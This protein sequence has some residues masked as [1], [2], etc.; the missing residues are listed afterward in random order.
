MAVRTPT[1]RASPQAEH[2]R[3]RTLP[4]LT[5]L[6]HQRTGRQAAGYA[7]ATLGTV[8][9]TLGLLG[10]RDH[11][12]LLSKGL[13]FLVVVVVAAAVGGL[14]PGLLASLLGFLSFNLFFVPPYG[15]VV[16][17]RVEHDVVLVVFLGLSILISALLARANE[18]AAAAEA[19][20]D[21]RGSPTTTRRCGCRSWSVGRPWACWSSTASARRLLQQRAGCCGRS[22]TSSPWCWSGTGCWM[23]PPRPRPSGGPISCAG[24]CWRRS[25]TICAARWPPSKH[26]P[27]TCSPPTPS[28]A[29]TPCGRPLR[30]ST[31]R[32]TGWRR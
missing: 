32:P 12:T 13:G 19:R 8:A 24:R 25:P 27:A 4:V 30:A 6:Q 29:R 2:T 31:P 18:R 26:R 11:T 15:T 5:W 28:T 20:G 3:V 14:G 22:V 10:V 16:L 23:S 7:A 9:L 21:G 1:G 17:T